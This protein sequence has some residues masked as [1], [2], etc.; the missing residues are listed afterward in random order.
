MAGKWNRAH[1]FARKK[2][3]PRKVGHPV[4]VYGKRGRRRKYLT[5]THKPEEGKEDDYEQLLH[6]IDPDD[7]RD[8]FLKKKYDVSVEEKLDPPDKN[9]RIHEDDKEKIK[10]HKK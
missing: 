10:R 4:Y 8:C 9:Y 7:P 5:F 2:S 1:E 3:T 6:N